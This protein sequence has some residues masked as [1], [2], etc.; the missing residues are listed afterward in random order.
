MTDWLTTDFLTDWLAAALWKLVSQSPQSFFV[1]FVC[2]YW[3]CDLI[4][5][6]F[7]KIDRIIVRISALQFSS[8]IKIRRPSAQNSLDITVWSTFDI[9]A[10]KFQI[11]P[12]K[13]PVFDWLT[14]WQGSLTD[15]RRERVSQ[16]PIRGQ[17]VCWALIFPSSLNGPTDKKKTKKKVK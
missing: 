15:W 8:R 14:D 11:F 12:L 3:L 9:K 17:I 16:L 6:F 4:R 2:F 5:I 1:F 10:A 7:K 13:I